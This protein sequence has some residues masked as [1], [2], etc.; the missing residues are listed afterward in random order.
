MYFI[1]CLIFAEKHVDCVQVN[2]VV[3]AYGEPVKSVIITNHGQIV[4]HNKQAW[5]CTA[6]TSSKL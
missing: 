4:A 5:E 3:L 6:K 2:K 1:F